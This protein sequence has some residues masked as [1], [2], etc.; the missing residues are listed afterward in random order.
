M[1]RFFI[2]VPRAALQVFASLALIAASASA[3]PFIWMEGEAP[4][5]ANFTFETNAPRAV[6]LLSNGQW[7]NLTVAKE[8][9][10][11]KLPPDGFLLSYAFEAT[12]AGA[13]EFWLRL[14]L[15]WVRPPLEWR[16]DDGAWQS[17]PT[18]QLTTSLMQLGTWF[19]I[20]WA[21]AGTL[22]LSVGKHRLDLRCTQPGP[23]GRIMIGI[24]VLAWTPRGDS[25]VPEGRL[26][27]GETYDTDSDR[28]AAAQ[29][30]RFPSSVAPER[31][32][33]LSLPLD[34]PWQVARF[35][36]LNMDLAPYAP[37]LEL[38]AS[39]PWRWMGVPVPGNAWETR[40][41]LILGHRLVYR[42]RVDLP[43]AFAGRGFSLHFAGTC[44]IASVFVNGRFCGARQSVLVPWDCDITDALKPGEINVVQI[45]IKSAFYCMNP[46][47]KTPGRAPS[48]NEKRNLPAGFY[49]HV[50]W[51]DAVYPSSKGEGDGMAVGLV[52]PVTLIAT[53][54]AYVR[55][56]YIRTS[57][58]SNRLDAT[59]EITNTTAREQV[60]M[61]QIEAV[62]DRSG[63]TEK[64][65]APVPVTLGARQQQA[66]ELGGPWPDA[67]RWWPSEYTNDLPDCYRL[68]TTLLAEGQPVDCSETLFGFR[69]IRIQGRHF[70]LNGVPWRFYNWLD[71]PNPKTIKNP[72]GWLARYHAQNDGFHRFS[73]DHSSVFGYREKAIETLDRLGV[74]C[75]ASMC[76][77]GMFITQT[78]TSPV[79]WTNWQNHVR[80]VVRAYR[81]HPSIMHWSV[82]NEVMLVNAF[83]TQR[84]QYT[85][86][87]AKVAAL[88]ATAKE[89]DPT[90]DGYEDGAGDLGGRGPVNN[91]HYSWQWHEDVPRQLYAY[92]VS[93]PPPNRLADRP[94]AYRWDGQRPLIGG[95]EFFYG[96]RPFNVAWFG[97]PSVYR[98]QEQA[99]SAAGRYAR[100]ALEG[101][102]WQEA[103]GM[104]P[105]TG[106]PS[107]GA[108]KALARRAVF[109]REYNRCFAP[110]QEVLR[111][112]KLFNDTRRA[113]TLTLQWRVSLGGRQAAEG[114]KAY[115]LSAGCSTQDVLSFRMPLSR[116][117]LDGELQLLLF[118][119]K[120]CIFEDTKPLSVLPPPPAP[121]GIAAGALAVYDPSG[122]IARWL[123]DGRVSF[124]A[125]PSP[126]Q[127]P[128]STR[129][130]LIG[131]SALTADNKQAWAATVRTF[132]GAG[133][134]V[135]VLEQTQPLE[136]SELPIPGIRI[137]GLEK[138]K[139]RMG[140]FL[141]SGGRSGSIC[142]PVTRSHPVMR[143]LLADDFFTWAAGEANYQLS[144]ETPSRGAMAL[145]QAGPE[146]ALAPMIEIPLGAGSCL[147][148]QL[149]LG[150][151]L[152]SEP[153]A[154]M[155]LY[156]LLTWAGERASRPPRPA[157]TVGPHDSWMAWLEDL[158][159][160]LRQVA[161]P[162]EAFE[163]EPHVTLLP[164][165]KATLT[166]LVSN[167][168]TLRGFTEKG[169]WLMLSGLTPDGLDAFNTLVGLHQRIRPFHAEAVRLADP[170]NPLVM[171]I[172][173]RDLNQ[174]GYET[175][176]PWMNLQRVS[177]RVFGHVVDA[178]PNIA[179]FAADASAKV[180]DGLLASDFWHYV[181]YLPADGSET[182]KFRFDQPESIGALRLWLSG[183]YYWV[184]DLA[185]IFDNDEAQ[186]LRW[187]L[188]PKTAVQTLTFPPRQIRH[189]TLRLL[190]K[191]GDSKQ[192][193]VTVDEV[194]I[195]RQ[196]PAGGPTAEPLTTPAGLVR[197]P[198]GKGGV[199]LNQLIW[200]EP[201]L[202]DRPRNADARKLD[203]VD[204]ENAARK[205][206]I[207]S[208]LLRNL[209]AAFKTNDP[210]EASMLDALK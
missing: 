123:A 184:K 195:L 68:R 11:A 187:S 49:Q 150:E 107:P 75:R 65:F 209:G 130:L 29:V 192:E 151:K 59:V 46:E 173:D 56:A 189:I 180:T 13:Y 121:G 134:T 18:E 179:A 120:A 38:P 84:N 138:N 3:A 200:R 61:V 40:P 51:N 34:G 157:V 125:P 31:G 174:Q 81:N 20:G 23:D 92:P 160:D 69:D 112:V 50:K 106:V 113:E 177:A 95:E 47:S 67:K 207:M 129:I 48:L 94:L 98:S 91:V 166:W 165:D 167:A 12:E 162:M 117:R 24:D 8:N 109:V 185:V 5:K 78:L 196:P 194:A 197:Y 14:G 70:L 182:L 137:A 43:R 172:T 208:C 149:L 35:D 86:H 19:E 193:L 64:I 71:V 190:S 183:S 139:V 36:D 205:R 85:N 204:T 161:D 102:R 141:K 171:G 143:G 74:P 104:C 132:V 154:G 136:G 116:E 96:G 41:E 108:E 76:I 119:G 147:L 181:Q 188:E 145:V 140:E 17:L 191:Q 6:E 88:L 32:A 176:A 199:I 178:G 77:D 142:H 203:A 2:Q 124:A 153:V 168:K 63:K 60:L 100:L 28:A 82:G 79:L 83:N 73:A 26:K 42:T 27:P 169:G 10:A 198:M 202:S 146:L 133:K 122:R 101:A 201:P 155:V 16:L 90:R 206:A 58:A 114:R 156:N 30:F 110:G 4:L 158:G 44:Y 72:S 93:A 159:L 105:W 210:P 111:T 7:L 25:F 89:L 1:L 115:S 99:D 135:I 128:A 52:N 54:P 62:H 57:V 55:D 164:A 22:P 53:G 39:Y 127:I 80:Q 126:D 170:E 87:E 33:R 148:S 97:G 45:A 186:A 131:P 15:E 175:I 9:V 103:A 144:Y 21:K 152:E 37:V 163:G 118:S 66:V